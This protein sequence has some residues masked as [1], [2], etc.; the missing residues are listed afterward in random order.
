MCILYVPSIQHTTLTVLRLPQ[1]H[2]GKTVVD[3]YL[4][5][6]LVRE[7]WPFKDL[8]THHVECLLYEQILVPIGTQWVYMVYWVLYTH[9]VPLR[10][11]I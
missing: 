6:F 5:H 1:P 2:Q 10:V 9:R 7:I 11:P 3:V 4:Y 8:R